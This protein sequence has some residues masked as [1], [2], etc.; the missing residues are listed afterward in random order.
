MIIQSTVFSVPS[1][2][3]AQSWPRRGGRSRAYVPMFHLTIQPVASR[4]LWF[5]VCSGLLCLPSSSRARSRRRCQE[6]TLDENSEA[7]GSPR[8]PRGLQ[9]KRSLLIAK[10]RELSWSLSTASSWPWPN[11]PSS[12]LLVHGECGMVNRGSSRHRCRLI[13]LGSTVTSRIVS[14]P[15]AERAAQESRHIRHSPSNGHSV[16][17]C[18]SSPP[19][20]SP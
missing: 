17:C 5:S 7:R 8:S 3:L 13:Q 15:S 20:P 16:V 19:S 2:N 18:K 10:L 6:E 11:T 12:C 4:R 14:P 9:K 1:R